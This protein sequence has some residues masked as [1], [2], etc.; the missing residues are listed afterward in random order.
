MANQKNI[1]TK[2]NER[3]AVSL[4]IEKVAANLAKKDIAKWKSAWQQ[5][6]NIDNPN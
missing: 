1:K 5:A 3:L 6:L 4:K 2:T